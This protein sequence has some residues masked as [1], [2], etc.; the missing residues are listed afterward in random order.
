MGF[1]DFLCL[2]PM[3]RSRSQVRSEANSAEGRR[4]SLGTLPHSAPDLRIES[5]TLPTSVSSPAQ[6][7]KSNGM[8]IALFRVFH[9]T[10]PPCGTVN[11]VSGPTQPVTGTGQ[12]KRSEP[13]K[14]TVEPSATDENKSNWKSTT[15]A[16]TKLAIN[17]V[18]ESSDVFP[19]LKSVAGCLSAILDHCDVSLSPCHVSLDTHDCHSKRQHV[20]KQSSH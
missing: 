12:T 5:S 13:S 17:M 15:Y 2:P 18:K 4:A 7:Q 14:Q 3:R 19:P 8:G 6:L 16:T 11:V 1:R 9:L 20:A 10:I